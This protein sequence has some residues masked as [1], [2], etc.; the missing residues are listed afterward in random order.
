MAQLALWCQELDTRDGGYLRRFRWFGAEPF[1]QLAIRR[2][3]QQGEPDRIGDHVCLPQSTL[4]RL[5]R[6]HCIVYAELSRG[7]GVPFW[8]TVISRGLG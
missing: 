2:F 1:D 6:F 7:L 4:T 3:V 5:L 8:V